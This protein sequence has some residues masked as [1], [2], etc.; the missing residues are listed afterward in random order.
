MIRGEN[1]HKDA[2]SAIA[3]KYAITSLQFTDM[4]ADDAANLFIRE[5][6]IDSFHVFDFAVDQ[7]LF[8]ELNKIRKPML[9]LQFNNRGYPMTERTFG[10]ASSFK[11]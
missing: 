3:V 2:Y 1:Q 4:V 6:S 11:F 8:N 10:A 5:G 7:P 9:K